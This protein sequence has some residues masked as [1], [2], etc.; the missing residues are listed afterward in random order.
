[1]ISASVI[2]K[3]PDKSSPLHPGQFHNV[4]SG[5]GREEA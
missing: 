3:T 1:M 2:A 4:K 5:L